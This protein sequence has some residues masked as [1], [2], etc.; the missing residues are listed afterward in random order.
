MASATREG[1]LHLW[2]LS[3]EVAGKHRLVTA[4]AQIFRL[5]FDPESRFVVTGQFARG[6]PDKSRPMVVPTDGGEPWHLPRGE[7]DCL[8]RV[9]AVGPEG[10]LVA[11][12]CNFPQKECWNVRLWDMETGTSHVLD[13][14][15]DAGA[16]S[17]LV[18]APE[19]RLLV[20][21]GG[22]VHLWDVEERTHEQLGDRVRCFY[23]KLSRD[24]RTLACLSSEN[25]EGELFRR[26]FVYDREKANWRHLSRYESRAGHDALRSFAMSPD[27]TLLAAGDETGAVRL[28]SVSG[29]E[30]HLLLGHQ[31]TITEVAFSPDGKWIASAGDDATVRLW[32][33]P[34]G[35]PLHT[36]PFDELMQKLRSLTN[37]RAVPDEDSATG[38]RIDFD[39]FPGW[40]KVPTW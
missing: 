33:V 14:G 28:G 23:L 1:R 34:E 17:S 38:Y 3:P 12:G 19:G 16:V 25:R 37:F 26:V 8:R 15:E 29:D 22:R 35:Q 18:F 13:L 32:P 24:G 2:P 36:L 39:P 27:G 30:P 20:A 31:G 40:K 9:V 10:R 6:D 4:P 21:S 5:A 7:D 11:A